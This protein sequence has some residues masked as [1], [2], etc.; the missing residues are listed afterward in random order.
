MFFP[1]AGKPQFANVLKWPK[2]TRLRQR[3]CHSKIIEVRQISISSVSTV[4]CSTDGE[5]PMIFVFSNSTPC[6]L[7]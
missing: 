2:C 7:T 3:F 5:V 1:K 6:F 4:L